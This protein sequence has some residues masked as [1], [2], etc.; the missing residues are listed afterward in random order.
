MTSETR[1]AP[2]MLC[3]KYRGILAPWEITQQGKRFGFKCKKYANWEDVQVAPD[4]KRVL[5]EVGDALID[6]DDFDLAHFGHLCRV[7]ER[8]QRWTKDKETLSLEPDCCPRYEHLRRLVMQGARAPSI[9]DAI[10]MEHGFSLDDVA[11]EER[12]LLFLSVCA[13]QFFQGNKRFPA[14]MRE[15]LEAGST[16]SQH[17][18][19]IDTVNDAATLLYD[20]FGFTLETGE[21]GSAVMLLVE[22]LG[23]PNVPEITIREISTIRQIRPRAWVEETEQAG[24][25][26]AKLRYS[27]G[28]MIVQLNRLHPAFRAGPISASLNCAEL[29]SS[30]GMA[31]LDHLGDLDNLQDFFDTWGTHLKQSAK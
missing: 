16:L 2:E 4:S 21:R 3:L 8:V 15:R 14:S 18:A 25:R 11:E 5:R 29:W 31:L 27:E 30:L 13:H 19:F 1:I 6:E 28:T 20:E 12:W 10:L 24:A 23:L 9:V 7:W 26:V 22:E 17:V